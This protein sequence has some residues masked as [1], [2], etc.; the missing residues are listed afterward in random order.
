MSVGSGEEFCGLK[1]S[2]L[3]PSEE[4]VRIGVGGEGNKCVKTSL[5]W[6]C[7]S[8]RAFL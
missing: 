5:S 4:G 7:R 2:G 3:D 8:L 6:F 1:L